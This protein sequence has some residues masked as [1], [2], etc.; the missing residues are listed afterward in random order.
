MW[1]DSIA[2][3]HARQDQLLAERARATD[4][5]F[6]RFAVWLAERNSS[7][8]LGPTKAEVEASLAQLRRDLDVSPKTF[9]DLPNTVIDGNRVAQVAGGLSLSWPEAGPLLRAMRDAPNGGPA[10]EE[11]KRA[12]GRSAGGTPPEG[13]PENQNMTAFR[14]LLCNEDEGRR[15]FE[16]AWDAYQRRLPLYPVTGAGE[17][18]PP[19]GGWTLPLTVPR[20]RYTTASLVM[21]A[22]RWEAPAPYSFALWMRAVIGGQILT[23]NDDVHGSS[24][25]APDCAPKVVTYFFTGQL[26]GNTCQGVPVPTGTGGGG[27]QPL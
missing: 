23:V 21:A 17:A 8:D 22:H 15:D 3:P 16:S 7:F 5:D 24:G 19:C 25:Y 12:S 4:A 1:L 11:I 9:S 26:D 6:H 2:P 27:S 13:M 18:I 20:L 14:A 10:P